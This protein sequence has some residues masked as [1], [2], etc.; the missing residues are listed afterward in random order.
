MSS[1][2]VAF[3]YSSASDVSAVVPYICCQTSVQ[4]VATVV[5]LSVVSV[6]GSLCV[7]VCVIVNA[8]TREPFHTINKDMVKSWD[9]FENGCIPM[10]CGAHGV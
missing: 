10:H 8:I 2:T 9:D 3:R 7:C 4:S 5:L 1:Q 6:C